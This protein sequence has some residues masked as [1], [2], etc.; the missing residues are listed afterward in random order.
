[1]KREILTHPIDAELV[2]AE[3]EYFVEYFHNQGVSD[4]HV[5]F[6]FAWGMDYYPTSEWLEETIQLTDLINKVE[7]VQSKGIG[8]IGQDDL[9]VKVADLE[10]LFCND[11]D[12]HIV[13]EKDSQHIEHFYER[14]KEKKYN[15]AEWLKTNGPEPNKRIRSN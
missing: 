9:V 7:S 6:G 12:I 3:L 13:F 5:L 15:P 11:S 2:L 1:M 10:F 8:K 4:C 14:W